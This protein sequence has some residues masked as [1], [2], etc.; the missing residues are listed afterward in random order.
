MATGMLLLLFGECTT[1][2]DEFME[3]GKCYRGTIQLGMTT[4]SDDLDGRVLSE[5]ACEWNE[6]KIERAVASFQGEILQKPPSVSAIKV[7]GKRSYKQA[8]KGV[9]V[10]LALRPVFISEIRIVE[11]R[12]PFV[13]IEVSCGKGTYI[14]SI[15]RDLGEMMGC[16]GTLAALRR[17]A[18]GPYQIDYAWQLNEAIKQTEFLGR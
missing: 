2:S 9:A 11:L 6:D 15:A 12:N 3:L 18:I 1:R 16:G 8:R 10:D 14:R 17:T 4:D 5:S 7:D 13:T